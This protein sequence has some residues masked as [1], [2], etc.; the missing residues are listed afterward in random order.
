MVVLL[1]VVGMGSVRSKNA[2]GV[3]II[4]T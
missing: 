1:P 2:D 4:S 3:A